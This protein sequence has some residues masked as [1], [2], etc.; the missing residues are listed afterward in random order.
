M[1]FFLWLLL[2][3]MPSCHYNAQNIDK[4]KLDS[5][6]S[7]YDHSGRLFGS[8]EL[9]K[10]Y[11][12]L[13]KSYT[14]YQNLQL[15]KKNDSLTV[16]P[17]MW[18]TELFTMA[19]VLQL[20]EEGK[21]KLTNKLS[22]YYKEIPNSE[23][24]TLLDLLRHQSGL[25]KIDSLYRHGAVTKEKL[26]FYLK[27]NSKD[28]KNKYSKTDYLLLGFIIEDITGKTYKEELYTRIITKLGLRNTFYQEEI[29]KNRISKFYVYNN[30]QWKMKYNRPVEPYASMGGMY[31]NTHDLSL[32]IS[33]LYQGKLFNNKLVNKYIKVK[34]PK[35]SM[36][37][38]YGNREGINK[39]YGKGYFYKIYFLI[40]YFEKE[41]MVICLLSNGNNNMGLDYIS[42]SLRNGY[43][44]EPIKF[45]NF[46]LIDQWKVVAE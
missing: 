35:N 33:A 38:Y 31:S 25:G 40:E 2:I 7:L 12:T 24:I 21:L 6:F 10:D 36:A 39:Y 20:E 32:F 8:F 22:G 29:D 37:L 14:G 16:Y 41:N 11:K 34:D 27:N 23:N 5:L 15:N 45:P 3:I 13:Y 46:E 42:T 18:L 1:K 9:M 44:H 19:I 4:Q 30:D 43:N 17:I 28:I 26:L